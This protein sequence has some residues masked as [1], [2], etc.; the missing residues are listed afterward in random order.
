MFH[1]IE[2]DSQSQVKSAVIVISAPRRETTSEPRRRV[3]NM[4]AHRR[5]SGSRP[6]VPA[7]APGRVGPLPACRC[8]RAA[9]THRRAPAVPRPHRPLDRR[10]RRPGRP[11]LR[12]AEPHDQRRRQHADAPRRGRAHRRRRARRRRRRQR[13]LRPGRRSSCCSRRSAATLS[14]TPAPRSTR[15]CTTAS[16]TTTPSGTASAWC[17][18]TATARC[19]SGFTAST[20][21]IGHELAH[22]VVQHTANL[23]YQGQPGALNESIADVFGALTEQYLLGQTAAEA[24][25]LIGAEIFTEAVQGVALRSMIAPGP[26]TTTTSSAKTRSPP[27]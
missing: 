15:R 5:T 8:R 12:C 26:P 23:E 3:L 6:V 2:N 4:S 7:R 18:A 10:E 13:G 25:W 24:T 9:D 14:T 27:T 19:S 1:T 22:G 17:S 21:V 11:A 16:T 20:T